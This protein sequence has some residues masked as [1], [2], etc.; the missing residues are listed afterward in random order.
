MLALSVVFMLGQDVWLACS[1]IKEVL[2]TS[3]A[4]KQPAECTIA[5]SCV[6]NEQEPMCRAATHACYWHAPWVRS[7]W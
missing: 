5:C 2:C 1:W 7:L 4:M 3:T 6:L